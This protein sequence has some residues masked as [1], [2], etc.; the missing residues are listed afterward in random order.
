MK[1]FFEQFPDPQNNLAIIPNNTR[2]LNSRGQECH[3]RCLCKGFLR[4]KHRTLLSPFFVKVNVLFAFL[5]V[6]E[7]GSFVNG[8]LHNENFQKVCVHVGE[9]PVTTNL[10][11]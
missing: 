10:M 11:A 5:L 8:K 7:N 1:K 9:V 6:N 3:A 4:N 2:H